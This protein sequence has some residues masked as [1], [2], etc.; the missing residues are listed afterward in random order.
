MYELVTCN[1]MMDDNA[2]IWTFSLALT[3]LLNKIN[4]AFTL[5]KLNPLKVMVIGLLLCESR[6]TS[7]LTFSHMT[8][9]FIKY[10]T[11]IFDF[12]GNVVGFKVY[13]FCYKYVVHSLNNLI[14]CITQPYI[15]LEEFLLMR[16]CDK[17]L[18][19]K[20]RALKFVVSANYDLPP[21]ANN[22]SFGNLLQ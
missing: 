9:H 3:L 13:I 21:I 20:F 2:F 18:G 15:Y 17:S 19:I 10:C 12:I 5:W 7:L 14:H 1:R 4:I 16:C 22:Y 11:S 6:Y 8:I